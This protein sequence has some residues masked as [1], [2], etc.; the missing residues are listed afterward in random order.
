MPVL[1]TLLPQ[2][3]AVGWKSC[4]ITSSIFVLTEFFCFF[5]ATTIFHP[6]AVGPENLPFARGQAEECA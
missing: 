1:P 4:Q 2:Y 6:S 3:G 5:L